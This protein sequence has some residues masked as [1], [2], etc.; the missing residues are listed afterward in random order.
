MS[1]GS[2]KVMPCPEKTFKSKYA[3][4][5]TVGLQIIKKEITKQ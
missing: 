5:D 3:K 4:I 2:V 1:S